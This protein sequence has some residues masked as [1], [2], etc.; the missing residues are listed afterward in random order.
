MQEDRGTP[1][2]NHIAAEGK[3]GWG[4]TMLPGCC[5]SAEFPVKVVAVFSKHLPTPK[6][7]KDTG[8]I[9]EAESSI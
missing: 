3:P 4:V 9:K 6:C 5:A 2:N 1:M 8:G 7:S